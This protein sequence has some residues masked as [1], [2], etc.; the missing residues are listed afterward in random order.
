MLILHTGDFAEGLVKHCE[1]KW[2]NSS[3]LMCDNMEA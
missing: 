2:L 1:K 3:L